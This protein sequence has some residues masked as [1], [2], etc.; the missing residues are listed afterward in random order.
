MCNK[1]TKIVKKACNIKLFQPSLV[2]NVLLDNR[3]NINL[4]KKIIK[5]RKQVS[6]QFFIKNQLY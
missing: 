2:K 6:L 3:F 4:Y 5:F 1:R